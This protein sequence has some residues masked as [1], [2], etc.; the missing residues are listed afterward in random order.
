MKI[1]TFSVVFFF[2]SL[3]SFA[4]I[5]GRVLDKENQPLSGVNVILQGTQKG[6]QT[7]I[8]GKFEIINVT[9][10]QTLIV[11]Y[12][13]YKKEILKVT[14]PA[15]NV[16]LTLVPTNTNLDAVTVDGK[17]NKTRVPSKALRLDTPIKGL[18]QNVQVI[19]SEILETQ[20]VTN[21]MESAYRN[22]SGVS[23]IEHW[24]H[25]A[26]LNMRGF[27]LPAFRNGV[28]IQDSWGP[29]SEDVFIV[30][31]I[32]FV[33]GP[34]GFM[35]A[36]GEPGGFYNVVTKK[37]TEERITNVSLMAGSF[38]TY[39]GA[40]DLGGS[41][42]KDKR[43]TSRFNVMYQNTGN[44]RDFETS[45]RVGVA[46]SL[47]Y[48]ISDKTSVL[49]EFTYQ[50]LNT[51][52]G[53]AYVFG[54]VSRG[55]AS[56]D[57]NFSMVD[58]NFPTT[59]IDEVS[60]LT[61]FTHRFNDN[62]SFD[63]KY[64][65]MDYN[66]EGASAWLV[67]GT[68]VEDK[69]DTRRYIGIWDA[70]SEGQ[71]FQIYV[72]G[73]F[74]TG[75]LNHKVLT[76]F[77]FTEKNYWADFAQS[78]SPDTAQAFNIFNPTYGD[79]EIPTF[80]RSVDVKN[81][82]S[83]YTYGTNIRSFYAQDEVSFLDNKIR[84]TLAGR[85][86]QLTPQGE[87]TTDKFTP[88]IGLSGDILPQLTAYALY[89]QSFL[90]SQPPS[91]P[92][93]IKPGTVFDAVEG[94]IIEGGLK[95]RLFGDKLTATLSVYQ[96]VKNNLPIQSNEEILDPVSGAGTGRF[97]VLPDE[98]V[99]SKGF[100]VDIQGKITSDLSVTLNYANTNVEN[101]AGIKIAGH[102]KHITNGWLTYNFN[103]NSALKGFGASLG[104][105]Y[106]VDRSTWAWNADN[107]TDL[108]DYFRLDGA[109][110]WANKK[111]RIGLNIN[112]ILDE[113][114]YS[115]ANYGSYLYWQSEPGIN[116][117]LSVSYKL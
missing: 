114:L 62:W 72:N 77:D 38:D 59:D 104:Y 8:D 112:N 30:D 98:E 117:R 28:N 6:T 101:S 85:H 13:G 69:G 10:E 83:V 3:I 107:E 81:R 33:K 93:L 16:Q 23:N 46:P 87:E 7:D 42:T 58:S 80:D 51:L 24:G 36:T 61:K 55:Y 5:S 90:P 22:V 31:R 68:G 21:I 18:P 110:S 29:L 82:P 12:L 116:G 86:T 25:F 67:F 88:R 48:K 27:R 47:A 15:S 56:L 19:S 9:G 39:R 100:E 20:M 109:L 64:V 105:Q 111:W 79:R 49:A 35:M 40:I 2:M 4:Q 53:S 94:N 66:Q 113:Y 96:I 115:G 103:E 89:D 50:K 75:A 74:K 41:L 54:P 65:R 26:R 78:G 73:K 91:D 17:L 84:L 52:I 108:P 92:T 32:E 95:S 102:S 37:P 1:I 106:Q 63:A 97:Y 57:R 76:G 45:E 14:A 71:Y 11:S 43:L 44:H 70:I 99:T 60:L 34:S